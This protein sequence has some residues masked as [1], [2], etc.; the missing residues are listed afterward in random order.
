MKESM[1]KKKE[2]IEQECN[3]ESSQQV[4]LYNWN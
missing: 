2:S 3:K 1:K 4:S